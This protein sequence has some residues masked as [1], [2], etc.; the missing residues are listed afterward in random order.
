SIHGRPRN[1]RL[2]CGCRDLLALVDQTILDDLDKRGRWLAPSGHHTFL[3]CSTHVAPAG[4]F[5]TWITLMPSMSS[6]TSGA[7]GAPP[8]STTSSCNAVSFI[9]VRNTLMPSITSA[10]NEP[11][12][13]RP[14][15]SSVM[16]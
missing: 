11:K 2:Q 7:T 3:I 1:H 13:P 10:P 12:T 8:E 5:P 6:P 4:S 15:Y 9:S 14:L 16:A